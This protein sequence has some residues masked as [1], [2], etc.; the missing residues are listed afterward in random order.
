[1]LE[2]WPFTNFHDLNLDWII[3]TIKIYTKKVDDLYNFGLYDYVER[4]LAAHPEWTTTVRDDSITEPKLENDFFFKLKNEYGK[5]DFSNT[6]GTNYEILDCAMT[7]LN[8]ADD[9]YYGNL[10]VPNDVIYNNGS[11]SRPTSYNPDYTLGGKHPIDCQAF[12]SM[13][14]AGIGYEES[15]FGDGSN[16]PK[17]ANYNIPWLSNDLMDYTGFDKQFNYTQPTHSDGEYNRL[18]TWQQ[19][20]WFK[21]RGLLRPFTGTDNLKFGDIIYFGTSEGINHVVFYI[22]E[23]YDGLSVCLE[24]SNRA[25]GVA[26]SFSH[27]NLYGSNYWAQYVVSLPSV[28][29]KANTY[30]NIIA[31]KFLTQTDGA[32]Q[33]IEI[34]KTISPNSVLKVYAFCDVPNSYTGTDTYLS[35]V[36]D[37]YQ[38]IRTPVNPETKY[39]EIVVPV[40]KSRHNFASA[41]QVRYK[42]TSDGSNDLSDIP[43]ILKSVEILYAQNG[44]VPNNIIRSEYL[45]SDQANCRAD[46]ASQ[47][48][49]ILFTPQ[50]HNRNLLYFDAIFGQSNF[51][52][53]FIKVYRYTSSIYM[54][55]VFTT[56]D[57]YTIRY[58]SGTPTF[59]TVSDTDASRL[60][61]L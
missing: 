60:M 58:A 15:I 33:W 1:M 54:A 32:N 24:S 26:V 37:G 42:V 48:A 14:L 2:L 49:A 61:Y 34:N 20:K 43:V 3:R 27:K 56:T 21:D 39:Y 23:G 35:I 8:H 38:Y 41:N 5:P 44:V 10:G 30:E 25:D 40:D 12:V 59:T 36:V 31:T 22:C 55:V 57:F 16:T 19:A 18:V 28:S 7:W 51:N 13:V 45:P 11:W 9:L 47:L 29:D 6:T 52:Y 53:G 46:V 17:Y 50:Y 4:V